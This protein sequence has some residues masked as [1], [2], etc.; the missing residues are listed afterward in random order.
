MSERLDWSRD[1]AD[2]PN[3]TASRFVEAGGVRW[4]VQVAGSG[5]GLLLLHGTGASTH[6]WRDV[7]PRLSARHTVVAPD[8]PGHGFSPKP[9][10]DGMSLPGMA[11]SLAALLG[12]LS[13][14]AERGVGH[15]AGAAILSRMAIDRLVSPLGIVSLNGA[16]VPF[17]GPFRVF[18]PMAKFLASTSLAARIAASRAK[19]P[20]A[21]KRVLDSTGS[22]IDAQSAALYERLVRS[23]AHVAGALAMMAS[24]DLDA[25]WRDLPRLDVPL[26]L[27]AGSRDGTV[28]PS[29]ADRVAARV[30]LGRVERLSG[31]GH[32]AHEESPDRVCAAIDAFFSLSP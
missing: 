19:D 30:R 31:L 4:H 26:L 12:A 11:R 14:R 15:S 23:P 6:S 8:L 18:S 5:P 7:L 24:W 17:T 27:V 28:S 13:V 2:W 29:Q 16:F 20:R 10:G 25:L 22:T 3:R 1:G 32:L 9:G 21:V